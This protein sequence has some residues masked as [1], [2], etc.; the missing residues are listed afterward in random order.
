MKSLNVFHKEICYTLTQ[1][2]AVPAAPRGYA[3]VL[4]KSCQQ[5]QTFVLHL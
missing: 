2:G 3:P 5:M 4:G 1:R